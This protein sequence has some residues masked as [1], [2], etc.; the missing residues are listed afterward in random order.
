[1]E[2]KLQKENTYS[3]LKSKLA[4]VYQARVDIVEKADPQYFS[5]SVGQAELLN[6]AL[7]SQY[8]KKLSS[9][10]EL[11]KIHDDYFSTLCFHENQED[12]L[13]P[14]RNAH[15]NI[16]FNQQNFRRLVHT[17]AEDAGVDE[18]YNA[19]EEIPPQKAPINHH[20]DIKNWEEM[21]HSQVLAAPI[22]SY[23]LN[24]ERQPV[25]KIEQHRIDSYCNER[26]VQVVRKNLNIIFNQKHQYNH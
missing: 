24:G 15:W 8:V 7:I 17:F 20:G 10:Y 22:R 16:D 14:L 1:M 3:L 25:R 18:F 6:M 5:S 13:A 11:K 9:D 26:L 12:F 21:K 19:M 2:R 23:Y 4:P